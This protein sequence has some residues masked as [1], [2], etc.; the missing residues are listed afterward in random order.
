MNAGAAIPVIFEALLFITAVE[1]KLTTLVPMV[2]CASSI[3][4][5][6]RFQTK[7]SERIIQFILA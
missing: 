7:V 4:V 1:V 5:G 3:L 2:L 6:T